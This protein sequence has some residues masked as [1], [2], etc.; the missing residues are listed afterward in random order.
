M[1]LPNRKMYWN[2]RCSSELSSKAMLRNRFDKIMMVLHFNDNN[3]IRPRDDPLYNKCQKSNH[4]L[5]IFVLFSRTLF[6]LRHFIFPS[7]EYTV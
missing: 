1:K 4:F 5:T 6:C 7:K 2:T 3:E